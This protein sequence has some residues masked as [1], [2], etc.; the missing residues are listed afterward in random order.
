LVKVEICSGVRVD[1]RGPA[2]MEGEFH[3]G[4]PA[5]TVT[6]SSSANSGWLGT[7]Y[8]VS[9]GPW[10]SFMNS[11]SNLILFGKNIMISRRW[12]ALKLPDRDGDQ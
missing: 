5:A 12:I 11:I 8:E 9:N 3:A 1:E 2:G 4:M 6:S 10:P 7:H